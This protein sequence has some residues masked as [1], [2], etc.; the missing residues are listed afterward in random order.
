MSTFRAWLAAGLLLAGGAAALNAQTLP[1][2]QARKQEQVQRQVQAMAR[3][4]VGS[5]L[6][7]QLQQLKENGLTSHPWYGEIRNM[8]THL[9]EMIKAE[10]PAVLALLTKTTKGTEDEQKQAFQQARLKGR[11]IVIRLLVERQSLLRRL[12][13]AEMAAQV[14]QLIVLQTKVLR[15]TEG[16]PEQ[17][18]SR[19]AAMNLTAIEDQRD[20]RATY[21]EFKTALTEVSHWTGPFGDEA[22]IGLQK[23]EKYKVDDE[24]KSAES[25]LQAAEL[26][27]ATVSQKAVIR[28]L[29]ELLILMREAQQIA[30]R[31]NDAV[32]QQIKEVI[33]KQQ[34]L[35]QQTEESQKE[36]PAEA[37]KLANEQS[38]LRKEIAAMAEAAQP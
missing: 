18:T 33:E 29:K 22:V 28:A 38:E 20:V 36:K 27:D 7:L 16:L 37:E 30:N 19:R 23:L 31:D 2:E 1:A 9:D 14:Q 6:D 25:H 13:I 11:E 32:A 8:Q 3:E 21:G 12:K 34:E 15:A 17:P 35:K 5:V 24:L 26:D 4:L 10:M